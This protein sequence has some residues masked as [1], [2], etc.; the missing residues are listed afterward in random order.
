MAT[1]K[2]S[3]DFDQL[4]TYFRENNFPAIEEN[5]KGMLF[6]KL[7]SISRKAT[8]MEFCTHYK[9]TT[10]GLS[11][12]NVLKYLFDS[13]QIHEGQLNNFIHQKY[14]AERR[15]RE[16]HQD[17][18]VDQLSRLHHFDWGGSYGNSLEKNIVNNYVKKIKSYDDINQEIEG[19][20][21]S[22]L[23]GYTLNSW[24]NH[25]TS[26]LIED[27]FKDHQDVLPAI[28]LIKKI[29]FFIHNIPF[30]LKVTY[31]PEQLLAEKLK[32]SG[33]GNELTKLKQVCRKLHIFIPS[34]LKDKTLRQHLYNKVSEDP[35]NDAKEFIKILDIQKQK[36][37]TE[38]KNNP[39]ELK[40]WFYE[41]Q[42]ETRF[43]A[44]NR[45][46][47]VLTDET[48]LAESWKLKR[49]INFLKTRIHQHL[50]TLSPDMS[51]LTTE[52]YWHKDQKYYHCKSDIL[53]LKYE[54]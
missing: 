35:R 22:S 8:L 50:T 31:F 5:K 29:D 20:L 32:N 51:D 48:N 6:L 18:L 34:D 37:I 44:S 46:F 3:L 38:A 47:L 52:F 53:F 33:Y 30:D 7:K 45:F 11:T 39:A 16:K 21:L 24:Y 40:K 27:I 19:S 41:N 23:R 49:N 42:G 10:K 54:G 2:N 9:I 25:W 13:K 43:D 12:K 14:Q 26:I 28:G 1:N 4:D 17:Y 15:E 36:I